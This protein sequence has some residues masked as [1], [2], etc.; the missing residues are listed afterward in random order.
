MA[1]LKTVRAAKRGSLTL[2]L[3]LAVTIAAEAGVW[4]IRDHLIAS[5]QQSE[6]ET[7]RVEARAKALDLRETLS[8]TLDQ[9]GALHSLASL[10]T[11]ARQTGN[12][13]ME[14]AARAEL[15]ARR[16]LMASNVTAVYGV[17]PA[18]YLDW[19]TANPGRLP[20]YVGDRPYLR[21]ITG[22]TA[23][24]V[25]GD[26]AL[27]LASHRLVIA[28]AKGVYNPGGALSGVTV[29][30][31]DAEALHGLA[32]TMGV[33]GRDTLTV[34]R[35]DGLV[36]ARS[37]GGF[38]G[39]TISPDNT[40]LRAVLDF[41]QSLTRVI[42]PID[43]VER[44]DAS[45]RLGDSGLSLAVGLDLQARLGR[46]TP[47]LDQ[48]RQDA[49]DIMLL[50]GLL[51]G[52]TI[53]VWHWRRRAAVA[54]AGMAVIRKSEA[55]FRR[56]AEDM[57]DLIR[58]LDRSGVV[59]YA[60]PA[61]RDLLGVE[62]ETLV[63]R[64]TGRFVHP[65]DAG[66]TGQQILRRNPN[67]RQASS[68]V[69]L[70]RKDGRVIQVQT[71]LGRIPAADRPDDVPAIVSSTRD[72]TN[73]REAEVALRRATEEL[74]AALHAVSGALFRS[75]TDNE[76]NGRIVFVSS[77]VEAITGFTAAEVMAMPNW[78][79]SRRDPSDEE[80]V[81]AHAERLR[82]EGR[83]NV[84]YRIRHK[85]ENWIWIEMSSRSLGEGRG[86]V[87]YFRDVT[88]ERERELRAARLSQLATLGELTTGM[89]HELNQP[90]AA[91]SMVAQNAMAVLDANDTSQAALSRKLQRI[92]KQVE[93]AASIIEHMRVFGRRE[94]GLPASVPVAAAINGAKAIAKAGLHRAGVR[95]FI[96][97]PP[98]LPQVTGQLVPLQ[99]VLI[100]MIGNA[101]SSIEGHAPR[102]A[103]ARRRI[104]LEA[105]LD[106]IVVVIRVAHHAGGIDESVIPHVFERSPSARPA[107]PKTGPGL[108][109][110]HEIITA[111]GGVMTARNEGDGAV[112][113]IRLPRATAGEPGATPA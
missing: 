3:W 35:R 46:L 40:L 49:R 55:L 104:D 20:I 52:G 84:H 54:A 18:L 36:V 80:P 100:N 78:L 112:F 19:S 7:V 10:V 88:L 92:V 11:K 111:M 90:L 23:T 50:I 58:L 107:G 13:D 102:L 64:L 51:G 43:G 108:S 69:R 5:A 73:E 101:V 42:S 59:L 38:V 6:I 99:Q 79:G 76:G 60:S 103:E 16:G 105:S 56:L 67:L 47:E 83:S 34:F 71:T 87:G 44:I 45:E 27:G 32:A 74:D 113:E 39:Q 65:D 12:A 110:S 37:D 62:P 91:I 29:V 31:V 95:L 25:I 1:T 85:N 24:E 66:A 22:G 21:M 93:R 94:T 28:F 70:V 4:A 30:A 98:G 97:V 2:I 41:R 26:P 8:R 68:E 81:L 77:S 106:G 57:P 63:G 96:R 17:T 48:I 109:I 86:A 72:V 9:I 14:T 61:T 15:G 82:T 33:T 89:A 53:L 75:N